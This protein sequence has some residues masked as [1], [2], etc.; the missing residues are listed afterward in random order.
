[1]AFID[2][3]VMDMLDTC[4]EN[5]DEEDEHDYL[6]GRGTRF[7]LPHEHYADIFDQEREIITTKAKL[8]EEAENEKRRM[9]NQIVTSN[10]PVKDIFIIKKETI[11]EKQ[12]AKE[13][14]FVSFTHDNMIKNSGINNSHDIVISSSKDF[15]AILN[16]QNDQIKS[17][18]GSYHP[19]SVI[20]LEN[21]NISSTLAEP[22]CDGLN[23]PN[24]FGNGLFGSKVLTE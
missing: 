20:K 24:S 11:E 12:K 14:S 6:S 18:S 15:N 19:P 17:N 5:P 7:N 8:K 2:S 13:N 1:M 23:P 3:D 22:F 10:P 4:A 9:N 21:G 16:S